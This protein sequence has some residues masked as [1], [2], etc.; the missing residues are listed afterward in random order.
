MKFSKALKLLRIWRDE[1]IELLQNHPELGTF[2]EKEDF[3]I[4][5]EQY[6]L[7]YKNFS[8]FAE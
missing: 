4:S 1:A 5:D 2:N 8:D 7:L 3:E 6:Y